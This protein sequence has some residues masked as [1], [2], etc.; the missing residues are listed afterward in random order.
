MSYFLVM[1]N[2]QKPE[3]FELADKDQPVSRLIRITLDS[4][5]GRKKVTATICP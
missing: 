5:A 4:E 3:W 1:E 2:N